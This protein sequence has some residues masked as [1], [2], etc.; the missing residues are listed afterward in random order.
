MANVYTQ[1]LLSEVAELWRT[2]EG[3][4]MTIKCEG[5][6][7]KTGVVEHN[8]F[9]ADTVERML[10]FVYT[11]N[12]QVPWTTPDVMTGAIR[13]S[14]SDSEADEVLVI[15]TSA[16]WI[17]H[18]R[19]YATGEYYQLPTLKN[20]A[21][22]EVQKVATA[23]L[24]LRDFV[25]VVREAC[26]L[27]GKHETGFHRIIQTVCRENVMELKRDKKFMAALAEVA[28]MQEFSASLLDQV[29]QELTKEKLYSATTKVF[30][31]MH[32]NDAQSDVE[33]LQR[34]I[35]WER[36]DHIDAMETFRA[37]MDHYQA[38]TEKLMDDIVNLPLRC[39][40]MQCRDT[41]KA[42]Y[43]LQREP[44]ATYGDG[45]VEIQCERCGSKLSK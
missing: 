41:T 11:R 23:P 21:L 35:G 4:D 15:G 14:E 25:Y 10:E 36:Q 43:T 24:E 22:E 44:H 12:Y 1:S 42:P 9:D 2:G 39:P 16:R 26:K 20:R 38:V 30:E 3:S 34:R 7:F 29:I 40:N 5:R 32:L 45:F 31:E 37:Q 6:E 13:T 18:T 28:D 17:A 8:T 27:I 19:M 33:R